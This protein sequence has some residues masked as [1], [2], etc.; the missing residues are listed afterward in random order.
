M[1]NIPFFR[2]PFNYYRYYN[3][4]NYYHNRGQGNLYKPQNN[5]SNEKSIQNINAVNSNNLNSNT[6]DNNSLNTSSENSSNEKRSFNNKP[7]FNSFGPILFNSHSFSD[8]EEPVL[9]IFG[10]K[11]YLDD[12]IILALLY[13]L[14]EED[15]KDDMLFI[16]LILLL[17][18][19]V[20]ANWGLTI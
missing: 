20:G 6:A 1:N 10:L 19:W 7:K 16:S 8:I 5:N 4:N 14:Y 9:E 17:L 13:F 3:P 18:S 11:L 2:P 12:L 15:V